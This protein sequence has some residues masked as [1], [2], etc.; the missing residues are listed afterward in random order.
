MLPISGFRIT[1]KLK[2]S[3]QNKFV[4]HEHHAKRAGLHWDIRI[5]HDD[6]LVSWATKKLPGLLN[7]E[8]KK[9]MV[10]KQ[11]DHSPDWINYSGTIDDGYGAGEVKIFD[12]GDVDIEKWEPNKIMVNFKG[13]IINGR[14]VFI[15]YDDKQ[16]L[17]FKLK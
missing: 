6:V 8:I 5:E 1:Q 12:T 10:F 2:K 15:K 13:K 4:I 7:G 11:P 9:I 14:F 3:I 17:F 16:W